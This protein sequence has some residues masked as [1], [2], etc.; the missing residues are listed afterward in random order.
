MASILATI[1][2][3]LP[4]SAMA[5]DQP[6]F[7]ARRVFNAGNYPFAVTVGDFNKDGILDVA[8]SGGSYPGG[9]SV[10]L[11]NG[12]GTFQPA[13][14]YTNAP[15]LNMVTAV[16]INH[17]TNLDLIAS[18]L[19]QGAWVMLGN[20]NGTFQPATQIPGPSGTPVAFG[21]ING[22]AI[23]D[24]VYVSSGSLG[25]V[26]ATNK[27]NGTFQTTGNYYN[28]AIAPVF[29]ALQDMN[30]D[31]RND[32]VTANVG[33]VGINPGGVSVLLGKGDGTFQNP[34]NTFVG[35][36]DQF[37]A[38]GDFN[39]DGTN[40]VAVTEYNSGTVT[41]LLGHG[42]GTFT[43]K[44]TYNIGAQAGPVAVGDFNLDGT[45]DLVVAAGTNVT[46]LVGNG[47][48]TF[49][50]P[51]RYDWSKLDT[52][53]GD[54]NGDGK[55]DLAACSLNNT[56]SIGIM[57]GNGNGTFQSAPHYAV[58]SNPKALAI[59]DLNGDSR[60]E[61][62][63]A[64]NGANNVS[65]LLNNG[66][67]TFKPRTNY[68]TGTAPISVAIGDFSA[69]GTND[70]VVAN[71]NSNAVSFLRGNGDGTFQPVT[72]A[73][74]VQ[75]GTSYV[76][77]GDF[78]NDHKLDLAALGL[79][80]VSVFPGNGNGTFQT[81]VAT[82]GPAEL[83][84]LAKA[85][86]NG[87]GTNDLVFDNY[88]A[89]TVSVM[90]GNGNGSFKTPVNYNA[91][92]NVQSLAV[93]DF[94]GDGTN[95]LAVGSAGAAFPANGN[96]TI[97]LNN[98]NGTFRLFTNYLSGSFASVAVADFNADG[99]AD[100]AVV[101]GAANQVDIMLGKGD[102]TFQPAYAFAVENGATFVSA[103]DLNGDGLPDLAV[104]N[105][106]SGN[107]SVL[108]NTHLSLGPALTALPIN[109]VNNTIT[110]SWQLAAGYTLETI[111]NL[112]FAN[113]QPPVGT[114]TTNGG[115]VNFTVNIGQ[116]SHFFR[117]YKQP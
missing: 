32:I 53:V 62:V 47:D 71:V 20:G 91:G 17:D 107:V 70:V 66:D 27:G 111:T 95:D 26:M 23:P 67:G 65:L 114:Q 81:A 39:H 73:G 87:D 56:T 116:G 38:V 109:A 6:S 59:G 30:N 57:L 75:F 49:Q 8:A 61:L 4:L 100:L 112:G 84:Q 19:S 113:W 97:L 98:G 10:L 101:E 106:A 54:F 44:A 108:L 18:G 34:T 42:D 78:N 72:T 64:N 103:G 41:I 74:S 63:V 28:P 21:N 104:V 52:V 85:D 68:V 9:V 115:N 58:G 13:V 50:T 82:S 7:A 92:T 60:P 77:S 25:I 43:N 31:G 48:G 2:C 93:G 94:N 37:L 55:E 80:G 83:D 33:T 117:L 89:N 110:F 105:A 16:D 36:N 96:I 22:D 40:D 88:G 24:L 79:L 51:T 15:F 1:L 102:G 45:N 12:D 3:Q 90:I 86:F 11:G 5:A 69:R 14:T 29:V 99:K 76:L 35:T 46:V